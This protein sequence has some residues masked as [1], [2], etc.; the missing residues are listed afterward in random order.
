[1]SQSKGKGCNI[2]QANYTGSG[3]RVVRKI[4]TSVIHGVTKLRPIEVRM[5]D[6]KISIRQIST[7]MLYGRGRGERKRNE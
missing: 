1:M 3:V 4:F 6:I 2:Q 5:G 7:P